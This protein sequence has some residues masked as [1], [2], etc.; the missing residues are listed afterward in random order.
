MNSR[1][2]SK[3]IENPERPSSSLR[4]RSYFQFP[5]MKI[6]AQ[7]GLDT[8]PGSPNY[9]LLELDLNTDLDFLK[10]PP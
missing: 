7:R 2:E 4:L 9:C 5:D 8:C 1:G 10:T 6:E 3:E